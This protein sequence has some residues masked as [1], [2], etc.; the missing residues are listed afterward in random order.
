M[1]RLRPEDLEWLTRFFGPGNDHRWSPELE[2][3]LAP[4]LDSIAT[5]DRPVLL[6]RARPDGVTTW[7]ALARDARQGREFRDLLLSFVGPSYS[8]FRGRTADLDPSDPVEAALIGRFDTV[9]RLTVGHRRDE[10]LAAHRLSLLLRLLNQ[11]PSTGPA[12]PRALR[13]VL[14]EFEFCLRGGDWAGAD[15]L[16][17]ELRVRGLLP[18]TP[19]TGLRIRW[20]ASQGRWEEILSLA[21]LPD[22]LSEQIPGQVREAIASAVFEAPLRPFQEVSCAP[23]AVARFRELGPQ[24]GNLFKSSLG[25][26]TPRALKAAVI[27]EASRSRPSLETLERLRGEYPAQA[28]DAADFAAL[29]DWAL[30]PPASAAPIAVAPAVVTNERALEVPSTPADPTAGALEAWHA[31][32]AP[33]AF[34]L[35]LTAPCTVEIVRLLIEAAIEIDTLDSSRAAINALA[36]CDPAVLDAALTRKS[37]RT[38]WEQLRSE[39]E[40]PPEELPAEVPADWPQWLDRVCRG[41]WPA[42]AEVASRGVREWSVAALR[43]DSEASA[44]FASK[45]S[46]AGSATALPAVRD[47]LPHLLSAFLENGVCEPRFKGICFQLLELTVLDDEL[48]PA[49]TGAI[50]D[51]AD[52]LLK[53]HLS[54]A[55]SENEYARLVELLQAAWSALKRPALLDWGLDLMDILAEHAVHRSTEITPLLQEILAEFRR[56]PG[57]V[58]RGQWSVI[59]ILTA[60]LDQPELHALAGVRPGAEEREGDRDEEFRRRLG[61]RTVALLTMSSRI[62]SVFRLTMERHFPDARIRILQ[63]GDGSKLLRDV[64]QSADV[65][66]VNTWDAPHAATGFVFQH[67]PEKAVTLRSLGKSAARQI[68]TLE[69]WLRSL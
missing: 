67:R 22:L 19:L 49:A 2:A 64:S 52:A 65:F 30:A 17:S 58:T 59:E 3:S 28:A 1:T 23:D 5:A 55:G 50:R 31:D 18:K 40:A 42:A 37:S 41:S 15:D 38:L 44:R 16:L 25:W 10:E 53:S 63:E 36:E 29:V 48:T 39:A 51:L 26:T 8:D 66:I 7:Y 46:Q 43:E 27:A 33:L 6:P 32:N 13:L 60:E 68:E 12:G 54:P 21:E 57:R 34:E 47:S 61:D 11:R 24:F 56:A 62:A 4:F 69:A 14:R 45:L 9:F 35:A 20:L